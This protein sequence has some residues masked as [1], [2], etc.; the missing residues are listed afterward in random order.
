MQKKA[1]LFGFFFPKTL[2]FC[3]NI[4]YTEMSKFVERKTNDEERSAMY[5]I[6]FNPLSCYGQGEAKAKQLQSIFQ[7]DDLHF[8]DMTKINSYAEFFSEPRGSVVICGGDGT[9]NRFINEVQGIGYPDD[10]YY[11]ATGSGNDF[12]HDLEKS[13]ATT[14]VRLNDYLRCLPTVT[15]NGKK[16]KFLNGVG[17]GIDGYCCEV[18]DELRKKNKKQVNYASIAIKGLLFHFKPRN[19]TITVDG[20]EYKYKKV[21]LAPT[22]NGRFY[23]G[24]MMVAP[25]QDRLGEEKTLSV[26]VMHKSG[27]LK[28]LMIFPSIFKGEHV[29]HKKI[30]AV[31]V[32]HEITVKFDRPTALQVDGETILGVTEYSAKFEE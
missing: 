29:K 23:G 11:F 28:T 20:T 1:Q 8:Y 14:P 5:S 13:S 16:Y 27:K 19:A 18:G 17:Y 25:E 12:L 7:D 3:P 15:V 2:I 6:L 32:G 9:L 24:G 31:H 26:V 21:W 22:M 4:C 30:V 10:L